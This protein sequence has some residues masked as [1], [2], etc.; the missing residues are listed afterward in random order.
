MFNSFYKQ[1]GFT[2]L[3]TLLSIAVISLI[4]GIG[5]PVYQS[6]QVRDDLDI[7]TTTIVQSA[8]RAE[9]LAQASDGDTSWGLHIQSGNIVLFKG[10]SYATRD[11]SYDEIFDLP[12]SILPSGL[13]EIVYAKFTGMPQ[14]TGAITLTSN[15][16]ETRI[17]TINAKGTVSF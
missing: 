8:R 10:A 16:N 3:E 17:I 11:S 13:S 9:I 14:T 1:K 15:A 2:L 5:V 6:F 7:S 12:T 4:A